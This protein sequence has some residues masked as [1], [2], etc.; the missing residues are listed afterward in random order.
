[1]S[2]YGDVPFGLRQIALYYAD[3]TGKVLLPAALML[4]VTPLLATAR[5]E[6]DGRLIGA[7]G[8]VAGAEWE[9]EGGGLSLE[10]LSRLTGDATVLAGSTPNRT[11][12][13]S[14]AAGD[15]MPYR[16]IV[17][18][19]VSDVGDVLC[20][21]YRCKCEALEGTFRDHEFWVTYAKGVAVSD[22]TRVFEFVQEETR[23]AL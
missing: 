5:F 22:G 18:R 15:A 2:G 4:H 13:M 8:F 21:L 1:M 23:A 9:F 12:T 6:A 20:K 11:L 16:Q 7:A 17:G 14:V 10:A 19:A 3:G